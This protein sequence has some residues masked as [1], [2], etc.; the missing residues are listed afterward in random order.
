ML[1]GAFFSHVILWVIGVMTVCAAV[2]SFA[3]TIR[4][5][6]VRTV[7]SAS[8]KSALVRIRKETGRRGGSVPSNV[9]ANTDRAV[10]GRSPVVGIDAPYRTGCRHY[11]VSTSVQLL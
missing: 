8:P 6:A 5:S 3:A 10:S 9:E 4:E 11:T 1:D 7:P 2:T